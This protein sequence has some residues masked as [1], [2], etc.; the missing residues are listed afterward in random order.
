MSRPESVDYV[1]GHSQ[2][3]LRRLAMQGEYW[4]D[5]SFDILRRAGV[6]PRMRVLD[7]GCGA[8]DLSFVAARLVGPEGAVVGIDQSAEAVGLAS[9]RALSTGTAHA[10]FQVADLETFEA[11]RPFDALVGRFVLMHLADPAAALRR[12][13]RFVRPGGRIAFLDLDLLAAR[14]VPAVPC[15]DAALEWVRE[16]LRRAGVPLDLGP[17]LWCLFK[18]AG[19]PE[20]ATL[21]RWRIEP[22]PAVGSSRYIAETVRSLLP[23]LERFDVARADAVEI[24]TLATRLQSAL[25]AEQAALL[26]PA[27]VGAWTQRP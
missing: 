15:V 17:R 22:A 5:A 11:G 1:L 20:P 9:V 2:E 8:G 21:V 12:L 19:L 6:A 25:V 3:E 26:S 7:V 24:E 27:V 23:I 4:S 10:R 14:T 16:A 18:A 13:A